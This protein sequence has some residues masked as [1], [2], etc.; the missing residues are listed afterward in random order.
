MGFT[1]AKT[2][3]SSQNSSRLIVASWSYMTLLSCLAA[4]R[5]VIH[6]PWSHVFILRQISPL[7]STFKC[8][9]HDGSKMK[10]INKLTVKLCCLIMIKLTYKWEAFHTHTQIC[11]FLCADIFWHHLCNTPHEGVEK[12]VRYLSSSALLFRSC[13]DGALCRTHYH[14]LKSRIRDHK[15][16]L[17]VLCELVHPCNFVYVSI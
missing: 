6:F 2:L 7:C 16:L 5:A 12:C 1:G 9:W 15:P 13:D 14:P 4:L 17:L 3:E 11:R 8:Y 10:V